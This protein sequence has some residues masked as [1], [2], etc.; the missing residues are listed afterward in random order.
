MT[1]PIAWMAVASVACLAVLSL[2]MGPESRGAVLLGSLAPLA[3]AV[4]TWIVV[5]RLHARKPEQVSGAMIKLLAAKM[6]FFGAYVA[7]AVTL[8][9]LSVRAFVVSFISQYIMLHVIEALFLRRLFAAP[10]RRIGVD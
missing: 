1:R 2:V 7:A 6:L 3:A 10:G 8:L 4:G 9:P 5:E